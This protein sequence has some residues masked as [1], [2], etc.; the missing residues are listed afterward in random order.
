M[1]TEHE[2]LTQTGTLTAVYGRAGPVRWGVAL[3]D[4]SG[5]IVSAY[6]YSEEVLPG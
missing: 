4:A 3:M 5:Q 1:T 6:R 2:P